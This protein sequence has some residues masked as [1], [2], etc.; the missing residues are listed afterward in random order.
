MNPVRHPT[1][2][3][4]LGKP[5]DWNEERQGQ[6]MML[7]ATVSFAQHNEDPPMFE[8]YWEPTPEEIAMLEVGGKVR[9]VVY[10]AKHPPVWVDVQP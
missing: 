6:C 9:L 8:T 3:I 4:E 5:K 1:T 7:P 2:N 10:G